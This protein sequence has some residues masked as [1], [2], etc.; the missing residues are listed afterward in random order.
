MEA[1][2]LTTHLPYQHQAAIFRALMHP[3]RI[4]I[5]HLLRDGP[6]CVCHLET[7]LGQQ[8]ALVSKHLAI[9]RDAGLVAD[10][11]RGWNSFYRVVRPDVFALLAAAQAMAGGEAPLAP[12]STPC[13]CPTCA[14]CAT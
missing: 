4:A 9:L 11:R 8:Q 13:P 7:Y 14:T 1:S 2:R 12:P 3:M 6:R 10:E 5:L